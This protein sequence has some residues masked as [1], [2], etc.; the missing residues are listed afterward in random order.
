MIIKLNNIVSNLKLLS[1]KQALES[2]KGK[3]QKI[4]KYSQLWENLNAYSYD[5]LSDGRL[6][7][8]FIVEP[9]QGE[10]FPSIIF[11][12]G[13]SKEFGMLDEESVFFRLG[14]L[15]SWGYVV[16]AS[17]YSGNDGG[18]GKDECGGMDVDDML[19]LKDILDQYDR[20]DSTKIG[21]FGASR[22]GMMAYMAL[23]RVDWLEAVAIRAGSSNEIRGYKLRPEV[24][25][26]RKDMYDVE[27]EEEN[28]KRSG[29]FWVDKM[30]KTTPILL[31]HGT[32]DEHLS[33]LDTIEM[34]AELYK[35]NIPFEMHI[36]QDDDHKM[37]KNSSEV[38]EKTRVWFDI[39]VKN[40]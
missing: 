24:K 1:P 12:R 11:N 23:K 20:A 32:G 18:E 17:Q 37:S 38:M 36:Y 4:Q 30:V 6:V 39:Y 8:G 25:E 35:N 33:V 34:G 13:G 29:L 7:K 21:M 28:L 19:N 9:K 22:G 5:Y 27:S 2:I 31:V 16:I 10:F 26:F 3:E 14:V 15:A 40:A